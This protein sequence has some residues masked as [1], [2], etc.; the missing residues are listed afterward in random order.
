ML[1]TFRNAAAASFNV[2]HVPSSRLGDT[3]FGEKIPEWGQVGESPDLGMF[4][5]AKFWESP[6]ANKHQLI[7]KSVRR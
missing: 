2:L 6:G 3:D 5:Q 1:G 4:L 7:C